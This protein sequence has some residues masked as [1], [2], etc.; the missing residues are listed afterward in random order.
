MAKKNTMIDELAV[1]EITKEIAAYESWKN[2]KDSVE[3]I[4]LL[5]IIFGQ[6]LYHTDDEQK[7]MLQRFAVKM[8][9]YYIGNPDKPVTVY[10]MYTWDTEDKTIYGDNYISKSGYEM[11]DQEN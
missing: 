1:S 5:G 2:S 6:E 11:F 10:R 9:A 3:E 8:S 4:I 7:K